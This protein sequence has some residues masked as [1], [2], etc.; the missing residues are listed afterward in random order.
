METEKDKKEEVDI[1]TLTTNKSVPILTTN[2]NEGGSLKT[3]SDNSV[4]KPS[5]NVEPYINLLHTEESE[6]KNEGGTSLNVKNKTELAPLK[7]VPII[8]VL[9]PM[10][11]DSMVVNYPSQ[12]PKVSDIENTKN[13]II[14]ESDNNIVTELD[15]ELE[16]IGKH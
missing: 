15:N 14:E 9:N 3:A 1:P 2:E 12:V 6:D 11:N 4:A 16:N 13:S 7:N 8:N 10:P 5:S